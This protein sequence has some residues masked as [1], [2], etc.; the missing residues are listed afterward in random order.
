VTSDNKKDILPTGKKVPV[1]ARYFFLKSGEGERNMQKINSRE[2]KVSKT[3]RV[4]K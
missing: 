4:V 3:S 1:P 2:L